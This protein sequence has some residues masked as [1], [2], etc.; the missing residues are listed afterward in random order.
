VIANT[1]CLNLVQGS[2]Y[3]RG[4]HSGT[5]GAVVDFGQSGV[6]VAKDKVTGLL[7]S[8]H[9]CLYLDEFTMLAQISDLS[10]PVQYGSYPN[11]ASPQ[12]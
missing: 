3:N 8:I 11:T 7:Y 1:V 4:S 6:G 9:V 5:F 2:D 12:G 10:K